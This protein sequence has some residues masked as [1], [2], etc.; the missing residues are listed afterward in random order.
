MPIQPLLPAAPLSGKLFFAARKSMKGTGY[1]NSRHLAS[2]KI[3]CPCSTSARRERHGPKS[4]TPKAQNCKSKEERNLVKP[5]SRAEDDKRRFAGPRRWGLC[6][7]PLHAA[8]HQRRAACAR[9]CTP[10]DGSRAHKF[11]SVPPESPMSYMRPAFEPYFS[12]RPQISKDW[13]ML[14]QLERAASSKGISFIHHWL[15]CLGSTFPLGSTL[16]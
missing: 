16:F 7:A 8:G 13:G 6:R 2:R 12:R 14:S 3:P 9:G 5:Q 11:F 4:H 15:L 10:P 1:P